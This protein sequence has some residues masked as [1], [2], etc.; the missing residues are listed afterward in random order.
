MTYDEYIYDI[1]KVNNL[2]TSKVLDKTRLYFAACINDKVIGQVYMKHIDME[3]RC[4]TLGIVLI[5]DNVKEK[6]YG[7]EAECLFI[8]YAKD[9]LGLLTIYA[10]TVNR[11]WRSKHIL[12][13]IGFVILSEDELFTYFELKIGATHAKEAD[14]RN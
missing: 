4:A 12:E 3:K 9:T 13:K 6:G 10:D 5:N 1:E 11:N 8:Q 2:Y 7:T 14:G